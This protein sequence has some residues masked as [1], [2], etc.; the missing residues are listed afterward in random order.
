MPTEPSAAV[1]GFRPHTYWTAVVALAGRPT[2]PRV[3]ERR[4]MVFATGTERFVFHQAAEADPGKAE[5]LIAATRAA[6]VANA[7]GDIATLVADLQRDG[8]R[9]RRAVVPA[10]VGRGLENLE[11]ILRA[12]SRIHAAEGNF[13]RD[14][15]AA[16]CEVVGLDV[17]RALERDLPDLVCA[18]AG[19]SAALLGA[20]VKSMGAALGPPW[21]EDYKLAT[22]A[23]WA[24][25]DDGQGQPAVE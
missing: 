11:E 23:A 1:L 14:V 5:P 13:Y 24:W 7:A 6:T 15:I 21:N 22:Q 18:R 9:V 10:G 8:V 17:H 25:L 3:I 20:R 4:R 19:F 12:H 16:A 2:S